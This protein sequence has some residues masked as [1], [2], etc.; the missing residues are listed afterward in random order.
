MVTVLVIPNYD[1]TEILRILLWINS[2]YFILKELCQY[3]HNTRYRSKPNQLS[4]NEA[5]QYYKQHTYMYH[6]IGNLHGCHSN[7]IRLPVV[8]LFLIWLQ[9]AIVLLNKVTHH[10]FED[11]A[12][13]RE[14]LQNVGGGCRGKPKHSD[15]TVLIVILTS[16]VLTTAAR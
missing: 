1:S 7:L 14:L 16:Q 9:S 3:G 8:Q 15:P 12:V 2:P 4:K 5:T 13:L 11:G 10:M 6:A